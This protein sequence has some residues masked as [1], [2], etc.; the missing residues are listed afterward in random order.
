[1]KLV[2]DISEDDL[3][4]VQ[5]DELFNKLSMVRY[6]DIVDTIIEAVKNGTPLPKEHGK[7]VD[8]SKITEVYFEQ[9]DGEIINGIKIPGRNRII[10]TN[11]PTIVEAESEE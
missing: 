4:D 8:E 6:I 1:M 10:G 2:I 5:D 11:A 7:I 3:L 9:I